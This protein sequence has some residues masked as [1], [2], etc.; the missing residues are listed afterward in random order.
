MDEL[1]GNFAS[2]ETVTDLFLGSIPFIRVFKAVAS[3]RAKNMGSD[4]LDCE[5]HE[6]DSCACFFAAF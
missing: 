2:P 1:Q 4:V 3:Q 5:L 6:E